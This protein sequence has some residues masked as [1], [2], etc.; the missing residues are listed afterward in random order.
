MFR[1]FSKCVARGGLIACKTTLNPSKVIK[2]EFRVK[3]IFVFPL[4]FSNQRHC[5]R[6]IYIYIFCAG[7]ILIQIRATLKCWTSLVNNPLP[8]THTFQFP[9]NLSVN[10]KYRITQSISICIC[11]L[12]TASHLKSFPLLDSLADVPSLTETKIYL[13]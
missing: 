3:K 9:E 2:K 12:Y 11:L 6:V 7:I 5:F 13:K 8:H 10:E 4:P 1:I